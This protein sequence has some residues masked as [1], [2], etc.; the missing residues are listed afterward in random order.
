MSEFHWNQ[1]TVAGLMTGDNKG[2][3]MC[4][5]LTLIYFMKAAGEGRRL[6]NWSKDKTVLNAA[7]DLSL[8]C[9][10]SF[11]ERDKFMEKELKLKYQRHDDNVTGDWKQALFAAFEKQHSSHVDWQCRALDIKPE[12]ENP[13][14]IGLVRTKD[15]FLFFDPSAGDVDV[16]T[17][18]ALEEFLSKKNYLT[19][20]RFAGGTKAYSEMKLQFIKVSD[21]ARPN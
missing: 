8:K 3:G 19:K 4:Q 12:G 15:G 10:N 14:V 2:A 18:K 5:G 20:K 1:A 7:N 6:Q 9:R 17:I 13:H 11:A 21:Y 16:K